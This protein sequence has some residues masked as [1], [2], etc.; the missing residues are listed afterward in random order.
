MKGKVLVFS[1]I[2]GL[3]ALGAW[4]ATAQV[5]G[6]APTKAPGISKVAKGDFT[7][8]PAHKAK[9]SIAL[10]AGAR[11]EKSPETVIE[12][13][14]DNG[15]MA[16]S[17]GCSGGCA[18]WWGTGFTPAPTDFPFALTQFKIIWPTG[19][20]DPTEN[21]QICILEDTDGDGNPIN[22]TVKYTE[23]VHPKNADAVTWSVYDL[24]T[25]Q[26][27]N[28]PGDIYIGIINVEGRANYPAAI[29]D[30]TD[31]GKSY[32][33][34]WDATP[35]P[36]PPTW[37]PEYLDTIGNTC[38]P[39]N[40]NIRGTGVTPPPPVLAI[41]ST[42]FKD[43]CPY[44]GGNNDTF[45]DPGETITYTVKIKNTGFATATNVVA[46][47]SSVYPITITSGT[48][49]VG[50]VA[51]GATGTAVF[52]FTLP[53]GATCGTLI[54]LGVTVTAD[55]E[56]Y[57]WNLGGTLRVG[58]Y[59]EGTTVTIFNQDFE[60]WPLAGWTI[61]NSGGEW[62]PGADGCF[63]DY[64]GG[65][66]EFATAD[67]YCNGAGFTSA[68]TSPVFSLIAPTGVYASAN[69]QYKTMFYDYYGSTTG[70]V[71]VTVNGGTTWTNLD[72]IAI[73]DEAILR[74]LHTLPLSPYIGQ[75]ACQVRFL[76]D[77]SDAYF[78]WQVDDAIVTGKYPDTCFSE[79]CLPP[80][81]VSILT[82]ID[83]RDLYQV[84]EICAQVTDPALVDHLNWYIDGV[85]IPGCQDLTTVP[86]CCTFD[87]QLYGIGAHTLR[88]EAVLLSADS[89]WSAPV[90][91]YTVGPV[92][93]FPDVWPPSGIVP[94]TAYFYAN[95]VW[96][97]GLYQFDWWISGLSGTG[98]AIPT[99]SDPSVSHTF[100]TAGD[101]LVTLF[102][103]DTKGTLDVK[104]DTIIITPPIKV[105]AVQLATPVNPASQH[106]SSMV[107]S[108]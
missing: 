12:F 88:V 4:G 57:T 107:G 42:S 33:G 81:Q 40:W 1:L 46:A 102:V 17:I 53:L 39:G 21:M 71:D 89:I 32:L 73:I 64:T 101:Y 6:A 76:F 47:L 38:C 30:V 63:N 55:Q 85:A 18:F 99:T 29:D 54:D 74:E 10:K 62:I 3:L 58:D 92:M 83:G 87:P 26:L 56:P 51:T 93:A 66:G 22:A 60:T 61:S 95:A 23:W 31:L 11:A 94:F 96:G 65:T 25:P 19:V 41:T 7:H 48:A 8:A 20:S 52:V 84:T 79:T 98:T 15:I 105:T 36:D 97:S 24:A 80:F 69:L 27:M 108:L 9:K 50:T 2:L 72:H 37:P 49:N 67:A 43:A 100:T 68:M 104:D 103:T 70:D 28:G 45:A 106:A 82:P 90:T 34:Q 75:S 14:I 35:V 59:T 78:V 86:Y 5:L 13:A 44:G 16:D 77:S 91:F